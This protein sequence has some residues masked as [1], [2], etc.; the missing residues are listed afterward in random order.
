MRNGVDKKEARLRTAD[1]GKLFLGVPKVICQWFGVEVTPEMLQD[2]RAGSPTSD[3]SAI[4]RA[5]LPAVC[6]RDERAFSSLSR[7]DD[8][9]RLVTDAVLLEIETE[10]GAV[11]A[12]GAVSKFVSVV[13][14][15]A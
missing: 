1:F 7:E 6:R 4:D 10:R 3:E 8:V 9:A 14:A 12:L 5:V 15:H 2:W 11:A 13:R